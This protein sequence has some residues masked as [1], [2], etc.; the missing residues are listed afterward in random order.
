MSGVTY[1]YNSWSTERSTNDLRDQLF[2]WRLHLCP[3]LRIPHIMILLSSK[4]TK[5]S[6]VSLPLSVFFCNG[7]EMQYVLPGYWQR[8]IVS[9]LGKGELKGSQKPTTPTSPYPAT[10]RKVGHRRELL[11]ARF[12]ILSFHRFNSIL[13]SRDF[14]FI[15]HP[16]F[17]HLFFW[18]YFETN[19]NGG[20]ITI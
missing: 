19:V 18:S 5:L 16:L 6:S 20:G 8:L 7:G 11:E 15:F 10:I 3:F 2:V 13:T 17:T 4:F 14:L 12:G 1:T 9:A